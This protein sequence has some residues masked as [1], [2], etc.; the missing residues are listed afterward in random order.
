MKS[1]IMSFWNISSWF[2]P[3]WES[4]KNNQWI[5]LH[6]PK[7]LKINFFFEWCKK[8]VKAHLI[9]IKQKMGGTIIIKYCLTMCQKIIHYIQRTFIRVAKKNFSFWI[10]NFCFPLDAFRF[11]WIHNLSRLFQAILTLAHKH[12]FIFSYKI[13]E[14]KCHEIFNWHLDV[15]MRPIVG[16]AHDTKKS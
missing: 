9:F 13:N 10:S 4:E 2:V 12:F 7:K 14:K 15:Y 8:L 3:E 11:E 5:S 1:W 16:K 6:E